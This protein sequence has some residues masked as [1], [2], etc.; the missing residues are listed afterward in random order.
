MRIDVPHLSD[1]FDMPE[2]LQRAQQDQFIQKKIKELQEAAMPQP[3]QGGGTLGNAIKS[4]TDA[5]SQKATRTPNLGVKGAL[6]PEEFKT[7]QSTVLAERQMEQQE[8][9]TRRQQAIQERNAATNEAI[10]RQNS[11]AHRLRVAEY[12]REANEPKEDK[13]QL[14]MGKDGEINLWN[15]TKR[16]LSTLREGTSEHK[17]DYVVAPNGVLID[18]N[19][20]KNLGISFAPTRPAG[21]G[22]AIRQIKAYPRHNADGTITQMYH[23]PGNPQAVY[24]GF[25]YMPPEKPGE[26]IPSS[27]F[28][29]AD[30]DLAGIYID[31]IRNAIASDGTLPDGLVE[32]ILGPQGLESDNL[33][34]RQKALTTGLAKTG[35]MN[36]YLIERNKY[37]RGLMDPSVGTDWTKSVVGIGKDP[38][39]VDGFTFFPDEGAPVPVNTPVAVVNDDGSLYKYINGGK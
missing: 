24:E 4:I 39:A 30:T 23:P 26:P 5:H 1:G 18:K 34:I 17:P 29:R 15:S 6:M 16:E 13:T 32:S 2:G 14:V 33:E 3:P 25:T 22:T 31:K 37:A 27:I 9:A 20:P 38:H 19:D 8:K 11:E 10:Q 7:L 36:E 28:A 21:T 12:L 35:L